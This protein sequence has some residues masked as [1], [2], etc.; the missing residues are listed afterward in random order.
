MPLTSFPRGYCFVNTLFFRQL[1]VWHGCCS[2]PIAM[3]T[4]DSIFG[5]HEAAL[6]L[7]GER[8]GVL[9]A[10]LA[11]ADTPNFK[12]RDLDFAAVLSD[13]GEKSLGLIRTSALH[14]ENAADALGGGDLKY[15]IPFQPAL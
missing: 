1:G 8:V 3:N 10:N 5:I 11:N 9:A 13:Q 12:A 7:R 4:F 2:C 6:K 14:L 15:R